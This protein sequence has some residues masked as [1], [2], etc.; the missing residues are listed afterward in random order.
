MDPHE[1]LE[2]LHDDAKRLLG[3]GERLQHLIPAW[4]H[5]PRERG[6]QRPLALILTNKRILLCSVRA[7]LFGSLS[8]GH[9]MREFPRS[10]LIGYSH[11]KWMETKSFGHHLFISERFRDDVLRADTWNRRS[12]AERNS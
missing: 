6:A 9:V 11:E 2:G 10:T 1:R 5:R 8:L 7:R 12:P 4:F 3:D